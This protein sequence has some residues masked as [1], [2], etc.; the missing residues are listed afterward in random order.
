M[1]LLA[2]EIVKALVITYQDIQQRNPVLVG[3]EGSWPGG[4]VS[5]E[6]A[7][8]VVCRP[9]PVAIFCTECTQ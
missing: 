2:R 3:K 7:L 9:N 6:G 4:R 5:P 1:R 8:L